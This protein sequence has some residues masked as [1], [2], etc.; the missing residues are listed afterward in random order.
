MAIL[1]RES[2]GHVQ[3][4][5]EG[6]AGIAATLNHMVRLAKQ[7]KTHPGIRATAERIVDHVPGKDSRGEVA[8]I[9]EWIKSNIRY[10]MDVRDVETLKT[11]FLTLTSYNGDCD[12][13]SLLAA[14]MLESIG[15]KTR[16]VAVGFDGPDSYSHVFA[17][18]L[19]GTRWL[20]LETTEPVSLGWR[21][22]GISV[23][24]IRHV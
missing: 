4:I 21:P 6:A 9:Q 12:D 7:F 15:Y 18:V 14:T 17:E 22:A 23:Q 8:A 20:P 2:F 11:P 10:T 5:P 13:Q 1:S 16:F 24:M 19:L 3:A